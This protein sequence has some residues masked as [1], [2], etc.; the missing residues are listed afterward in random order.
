MGKSVE[1]VGATSGKGVEPKGQIGLKTRSYALSR[2]A[3]AH[4]LPSYV[5]LRT[6]PRRRTAPG[7]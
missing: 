7:A 1:T 6:R 5:L 2:C 4:L 3:S